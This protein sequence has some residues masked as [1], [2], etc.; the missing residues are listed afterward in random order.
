MMTVVSPNG[1]FNNRFFSSFQN[2]IEEYS[3]YLYH[4]GEIE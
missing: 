2:V 3:H 4:N 1:W